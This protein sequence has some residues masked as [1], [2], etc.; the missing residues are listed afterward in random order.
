VDSD[1][2][3]SLYLY[4][5]RIRKKLGYN[6]RPWVLTRSGALNFIDMKTYSIVLKGITPYMQHRM[7]DQKLED[8][9][10][11]R[12]KIIERDDIS[13]ETAIRAEYHCYRNNEGYCYI[14][15]EQL[16][17]SLINAGSFMK[18]KVGNAK[19]SMKNIVA[20][21]IDV[22]PA[23]I[24]VPDYDQIDKRS[25]VNKNVKARVITI[26]PK[27]SDWEIKCKI[28]VDDDTLTKETIVDLINYA[29]KYCGIGS[30]RP[31]NN[32]RFGRFELKEI[33]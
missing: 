24:I 27:W 13:R 20:A 17:A 26:R 15:A 5:V 4:C 18:S 21:M 29:G 23:E 8:W 2:S 10:K 32:G 25:A 22:L 7:D 16:R 14:P 19:K 12:K 3:L 1:N 28:E 11:S 33:K 30:F 9:E 6:L 31:T